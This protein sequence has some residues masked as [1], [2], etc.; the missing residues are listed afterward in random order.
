MLSGHKKVKMVL[1]IKFQDKTKSKRC[2]SRNDSRKVPLLERKGHL[3]WNMFNV[4]W[5]FPKR[6]TSE[7]HTPLR[8]TDV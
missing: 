4:I 5:A 8:Q 7:A 3:F 2:D 6:H 1:E